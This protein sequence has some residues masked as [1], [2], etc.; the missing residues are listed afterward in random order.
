MSVIRH[1]GQMIQTYRIYLRELPAVVF[2]EYLLFDDMPQVW[3][4]LFAKYPKSCFF[5]HTYL[6][7]H[8]LSAYREVLQVSCLQIILTTLTYTDNIKTF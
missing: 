2:P 1:V 8:T 7:N 6:D 4:D 5:F 3:T